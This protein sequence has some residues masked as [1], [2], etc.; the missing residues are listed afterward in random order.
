MTLLSL[1]AATVLFW[2]ANA[3][4]EESPALKPSPSSD[5]APANEAKPLRDPTVMSPRF[6]EAL[7]NLSPPSTQPMPGGQNNAAP[8]PL[9]KIPPIRLIGL[10]SGS[11]GEPSALLEIGKEQPYLVVKGSEISL[12]S[13]DSSAG[14]SIEVKSVTRSGV[15]LLVKPYNKTIILR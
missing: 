13:D 2:T 10:I 7:R 6:R 1:A 11:A 14:G 4:A 8:P 9:P 5:A 3:L 15:Q 12:T